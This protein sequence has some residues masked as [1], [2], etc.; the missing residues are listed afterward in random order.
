M[1]VS[2]GEFGLDQGMV[3]LMVENF[4]SGLLWRLLRSCP[5]PA[6]RFAPR[7]LSRWLAGCS[8]ALLNE[9]NPKSR[10]LLASALHRTRSSAALPHAPM[11]NTRPADWHNPTTHERFDLLVIGAGPDGM[12]AARTVAAAGARVALIERYQLGGNCINEGCIPPKPCCAAPSCTQKCA[13][14][15]AMG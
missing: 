10:M 9:A 15:S 14:R 5:F 12:V 3:V 1:W 6:H 4:R 11:P 8:R 7:R 2:E 13:R